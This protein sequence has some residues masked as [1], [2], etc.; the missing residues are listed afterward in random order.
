MTG[1]I[2]QKIYQGKT[3]NQSESYNLFT[4][5]IKG[6]LSHCQLAGV[7]VAMKI[8][9]EEPE[10]IAGAAVAMME[11][12]LP[13]PR[14]DY[15]FADIVGTGG[16]GSNS[17]NISTASALVAA[18]CGL[19][20]AK[21]GGGSVSGKSGASDI[22]NAFGFRLDLPASEARDRLDNS[23]FCFLHAPHYHTGFRHAISVRQQLKTRTL[24]NILGPLINPARPPLAV[25]G[26]YSPELLIPVAQSLTMLHYQRAMVVHGNGMDEVVLHGPTH[27]AELHAG[28]ITFYQLSPEDFGLHYYNKHTLTGGTPEMN[29]MLL[30]QMFQGNGHPAHEET[31]AANVALLLK[32]SGHE[33]LQQNARMA[34]ETI[35]SGEVYERVMALASRG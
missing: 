34:L 3:I 2:L 11:N 5:I 22:L 6:E 27:I 20:I 9:N 12:A 25:I 14:P 4:A 17:I 10:E 32:L 23:N 13:F 1:N 18:C 21:H 31:V 26:V 16:D 7:L 19:K 28:K 24:F 35:R 29:H 8:R 15:D 30:T 33:D